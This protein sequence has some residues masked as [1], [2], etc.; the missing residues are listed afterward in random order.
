MLFGLS[1]IQKRIAIRQLIFSD[2]KVE[3]NYKIL[4]TKAAF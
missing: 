1:S 4:E 2:A 3:K